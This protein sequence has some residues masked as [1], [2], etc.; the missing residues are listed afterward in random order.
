MLITEHWFDG[1]AKVLS[2][3]PNDKKL[4]NATDKNFVA[5][6]VRKVV[7]GWPQQPHDITDGAEARIG[8]QLSQAA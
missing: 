5:C 4:K 6:N 3:F 2:R 1:G 7:N 8:L